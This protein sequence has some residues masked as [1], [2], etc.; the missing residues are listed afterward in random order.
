MAFMF[1]RRAPTIAPSLNEMK[2]N[3][4]TAHETNYDPP[5]LESVQ[6]FTVRVLTKLPGAGGRLGDIRAVIAY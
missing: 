6:S 4:A 1:F 2:A 3:D 5:H